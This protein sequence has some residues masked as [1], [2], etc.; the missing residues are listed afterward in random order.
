MTGR[1]V[2]Q[3]YVQTPPSATGGIVMTAL[4][5]AGFHAVDG[6][7]IVNGLIA[8][9]KTAEMVMQIR[10]LT[11]GFISKRMKYAPPTGKLLV[12]IR[13][14]YT[15]HVYPGVHQPEVYFPASAQTSNGRM[16]SHSGTPIQ[17][18]DWSPAFS[19]K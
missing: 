4:A 14:V 11:R 17:R 18:P 16:V 2:A 7:S 5:H 6:V 10:Q 15:D 1:Q 9:L 12:D 3:L 13:A 19:S 8:L